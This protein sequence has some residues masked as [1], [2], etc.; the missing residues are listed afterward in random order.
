MREMVEGR[1]RLL[2]KLCSVNPVVVG[3]VAVVTERGRRRESWVY[4]QDLYSACY[5]IGRWEGES[6][7]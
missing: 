5:M 1:I 4:K 6:V 2:R 3:D 7:R